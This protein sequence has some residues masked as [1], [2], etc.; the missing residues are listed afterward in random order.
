VS[1]VEFDH[2]PSLNADEI[3]SI[4]SQY[5]TSANVVCSASKEGTE[6]RTTL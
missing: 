4:G 2:Q 3:R 5:M 6:G 1:H